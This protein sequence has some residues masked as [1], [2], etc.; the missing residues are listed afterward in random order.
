MGQKPPRPC[1]RAGC[2][3]LTLAGYCPAHQPKPAPRQESAAWHGLY[4]TKAWRETLRPR[5]LLREPFCR[6]CSELGVRRRAT[7][8]D[9]VRPHRGDT[10]V[11]FDA[12]NLQSL[13]KNHHD[14]KTMRERRE[15][16]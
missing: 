2:N 12:T 5:Q 4:A 7:V 8:V 9:H 10:K 13:C 3:A 11:F 6:A 16:A 1:L 14:A 15:R